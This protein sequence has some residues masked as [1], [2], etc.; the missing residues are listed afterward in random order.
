MGLR[1]RAVVRKRDFGRRGTP[2]ERLLALE[3][4]LPVRVVD[5]GLRKSPEQE[6]VELGLVAAGC[7]GTTARR[8]RGARRRR[9]ASLNKDAESKP[10]TARSL[11]KH[12]RPSLT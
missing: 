11:F 2:G 4:V 1:V 5:L 7:A 10:Q 12:P 6:F 9:R 8:W 3:R